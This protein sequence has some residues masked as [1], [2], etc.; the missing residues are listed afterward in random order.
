MSK[1]SQQVFVHEPPKVYTIS[2]AKDSASTSTGST[3]AKRAALSTPK[4][5]L[6]QQKQPQQVPP[7]DFQGELKE[8]CMTFFSSVT[9]TKADIVSDKTKL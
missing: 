8:K 3:E 2:S 9:R 6:K 5:V 7:E 4:M 1:I